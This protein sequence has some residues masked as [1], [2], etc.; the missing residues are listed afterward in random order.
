MEMLG[1]A[2][3][4]LFCKLI[5]QLMLST[6][7]LFLFNCTDPQAITRGLL[8]LADLTD[9]PI[10]AYPNSFHVPEGWT[11]DND[12]PV[13]RRDLHEHEFVDLAGKWFDIG[14]TIVGGC[15]GIGPGHIGALSEK[16]Q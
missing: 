12:I 13:E 5:R 7:T 6:L 4:I 8:E 16:I 10:G 2:A 1:C 9:K 14:A 11:L 3:E 15:C